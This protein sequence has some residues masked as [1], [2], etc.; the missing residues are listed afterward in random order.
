[1][2]VF[3]LWS[4]VSGLRPYD[5]RVQGCGCK[6]LG[7]GVFAGLVRGRG[8]LGKPLSQRVHVPNTLVLRIWV[9][10]IIVLV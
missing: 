10:V 3:S 6:V 7:F 4:R 9:I 8:C 2:K 5:L 1:M